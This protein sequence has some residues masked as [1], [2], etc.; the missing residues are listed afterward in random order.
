MSHM[1]R[2]QRHRDIFLTHQVRVQE[3]HPGEAYQGHQG[4][5]LEYDRA[6]HP[7]GR[8]GEGKEMRRRRTESHSGSGLVA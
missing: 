5:Q 3:A 6:E 8:I 2:L 1:A 4:G 7:E